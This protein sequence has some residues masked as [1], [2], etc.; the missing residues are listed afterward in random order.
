MAEDPGLG[1]R[2]TATITGVKGDCSAGHK[3]GES[4]EISCYNPGG[5]CGF[6]YHQIFP[7]LSTFQFGGSYPWWNGDIIEMQ[8]PDPSNAVT[9]KLERVK[10]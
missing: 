8:C 5:L 4:F 2:V 7:D 6:Y 3:V 1:Y 10:R 9:I